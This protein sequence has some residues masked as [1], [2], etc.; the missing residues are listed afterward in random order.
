MRIYL[1]LTTEDR[2]ALETAAP[3]LDLAAGRAAW[4]VH[5]EALRDRPD[6]DEEGLEYEALQDAVHIAYLAGP[7]DRR[8]LVV[9]ADASDATLEVAGEDG[10][11]FGVITAARTQARIASFHVTELDAAAADADD[12]DPAL[13]WFDASEGGD[14]LAFLDGAQQP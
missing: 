14:A 7:T 3:E 10:G 1:P 9:A 11:A 13:L 8:A 5:A 6:Q 12:T 4:G 2:V